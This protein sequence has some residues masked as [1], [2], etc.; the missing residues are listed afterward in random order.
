MKYETV[1]PTMVDD[2]K[3]LGYSDIDQLVI[4]YHIK[5]LK[6]YLLGRETK[7]SARSSCDILRKLGMSPYQISRAVECRLTNL[8]FI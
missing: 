2:T 6:S 5:D 7:E 4:D 3:A 8:P 1:R